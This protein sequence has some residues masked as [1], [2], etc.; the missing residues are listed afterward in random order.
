MSSIPNLDAILE[1]A[2]SCGH[3]RLAVLRYWR[4]PVP[5]PT[6]SGPAIL[7]IISQRIPNYVAAGK[8]R[9]GWV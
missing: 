8:R 2:V 4:E 9:N 7:P 5:K 1:H 3:E 6:T